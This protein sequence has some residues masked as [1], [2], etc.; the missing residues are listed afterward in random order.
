MDYINKI[1]DGLL[2]KNERYYTKM[3]CVKKIM[4]KIIKII[5][6]LGDT[7]YKNK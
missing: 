5:G 2:Y 7:I 1:G 6:K 4:K 3:V